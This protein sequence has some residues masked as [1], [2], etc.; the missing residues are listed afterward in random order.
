[1]NINLNN[2]EE[3]FLLYA[4]KELSPAERMEVE[5]FVKEN[6]SLKE[7]F[8]AIQF[9]VTSPDQEIRLFDKSFLFRN[10]PS[11]SIGP[12]NYELYFIEYHD[13][14][15]NPDQETETLDFLKRH[16][17]L[18]EEFN[19][20]GKAKLEADESIVFPDKS[21]LYRKEKST[22]VVSLFIWRAMAAAVFIGFGLWFGV[23]LFTNSDTGTAPVIS[24]NRLSDSPIKS[25]PLTATENN[26][27]DGQTELSPTANTE[28]NLPEDKVAIQKEEKG[29]VVKAEKNQKKVSPVSPREKTVNNFEERRMEFNSQEPDQ[30]I[31]ANLPDHNLKNATITTLEGSMPSVNHIDQ[32]DPKFKPTAGAE[33]T[34]Y[35]TLAV[36]E[37]ADNQDYIFYNVPADE[38]KKTKVGGF[39]KKA[40]RV[41][42]R[43]NPIARMLS[44]D[45]NQVAAK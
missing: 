41:I 13:S 33:N 35:T 10:I 44:G 32:A 23:P 2:Y 20:I 45:D 15:L 19:L 24:D 38:F 6:P 42:E 16:P 30:L 39:L 31:A 17:E 1:M 3:Y 43:T 27:E 37:P 4:D 22:K 5:N 29:Q 34:T 25:E 8:D 26:K 12:D 14:E 11:S 9:T 21:V 36:E 18:Q 40:K 7:E 28:E